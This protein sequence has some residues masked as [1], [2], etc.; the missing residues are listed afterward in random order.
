MEDA[1]SLLKI[2]ESECPD[3]WIRPP[4]H[5][6]PKSWSSMED[7]V[8]PLERNLL[9]GHPFSRTVMGGAIRGSSSG[10]RMA[11]SS[12]LGGNAYSL[13]ERKDY[14][15][16]CTWTISKLQER[17]KIRILDHVYLGCSQRECKTSKE[18][19]DNYR[20]LSE[21]RMSAGGIEN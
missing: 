10:K 11:E 4:R 12:K 8:I 19:V 13:T 20:E 1:P 6:W 7:P 16:P 5:K 15:C 3:V 9:C 21:S 17:N 14:S 2:P 18:I